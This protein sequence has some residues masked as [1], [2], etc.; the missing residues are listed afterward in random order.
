MIITAS[1]FFNELDLF[2]L[3]CHTLDGIVDAHV[4]I[5]ATTTFTGKPKR[6]IYGENRDRFAAFKIIHHVVELPSIVTSPWDREHISHLHLLELVK[7]VDP[8]IVIWSDSDEIARPDTV[9]R[10]K[11]LQTPCATLDL[12]HLVYFPDR[13]R[14]D[15]RDTNPKIGLFDRAC[16]HQ[17]W[18]GETHWPVLADAGWHFEYM[19]ARQNLLDKLAA[20]SHA[21]E[22]RCQAMRE[23]VSRGLFPGL[24]R[25][26]PY[27]TDRLPPYL[28]N[29]PELFPLCNPLKP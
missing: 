13:I 23:E 9:E 1:L 16:E 27:P 3:R 7:K 12:D 25:S 17:P 26:E 24:D 11:E 21:P 8:R 5:E 4:I 15:I 10:F 29:H 6:L 18:R 20:I 22:E 28:L 14:P 19:G 2:E